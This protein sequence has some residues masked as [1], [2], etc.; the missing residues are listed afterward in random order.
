VNDLSG[1][2]TGRAGLAGEFVGVSVVRESRPRVLFVGELNPFGADPR[3]ALY[4]L[5]RKSSGNRLRCVLGLTDLEYHKLLD[6]ANLCDGKWS[7]SAARER[8][9]ELVDSRGPGGVVVLLGARVRGVARCIAREYGADLE[10]LPFSG[11][12]VGEGDRRRVLVSLPHPS[13]LC[14]L[15]NEPGAVTRAR[16]LL[17]VLAPGVAWGT[18]DGELPLS[19]TPREEVAGESRGGEG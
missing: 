17:T 5:P 7:S 4:H 12:E 15:W 16:R 19:G 1:A 11:L 2:S 8:L 18:C 9:V 10:L 3:Y 6:K 13:G 14:R